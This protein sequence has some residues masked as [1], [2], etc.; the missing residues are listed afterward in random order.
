MNNASADA[1]FLQPDDPNAKIWRYM[2]F[3]K[4]V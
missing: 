2:D 3:T 1:A 4:F